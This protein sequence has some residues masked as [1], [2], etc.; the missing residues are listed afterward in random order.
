MI[1]DALTE[2]RRKRLTK[3]GHS[4][5]DKLEGMLG[6]IVPPEVTAAWMTIGATRLE[7]F[8]RR[9]GKSERSFIRRSANDLAAITP[10]SR[11]GSRC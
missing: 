4:C 1:R 9:G 10:P 5:V 7:W 8:E 6:R 2:R 11:S 3:A